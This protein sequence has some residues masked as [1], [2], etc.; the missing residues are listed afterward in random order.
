MTKMTCSALRFCRLAL[1][2]SCVAK[3]AWPSF[4]DFA[5]G[6]AP[7]PPQLHASVRQQ[8]DVLDADLNL[9]QFQDRIDLAPFHSYLLLRCVAHG[10]NVITIGID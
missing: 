2:I 8:W 3:A 1:G 6:M 4:F 7:L 9:S 5:K 10:L